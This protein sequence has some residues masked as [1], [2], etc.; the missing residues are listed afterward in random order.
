M[1]KRNYFRLLY[2]NFNKGSGKIDLNLRQS[3]TIL[4]FIAILIGK[5]EKTTKR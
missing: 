2:Q 4:E 1:F 3:L 5:A